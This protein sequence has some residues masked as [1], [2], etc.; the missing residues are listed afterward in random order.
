MHMNIRTSKT[1]DRF[2]ADLKTHLFELELTVSVV[3]T[4]CREHL[5]LMNY[6]FE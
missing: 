3:N 5:L 2:K 6:A 1:V 4:G